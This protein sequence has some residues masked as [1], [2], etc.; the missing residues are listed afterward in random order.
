M[1][2]FLALLPALIMIV[3]VIT[4]RK[5]LISLGIGILIAAFIYAD[6]N[7]I[8][9]ITYIAES[10]WGIATSFDWY[11]PILGFVVIIG[12]I[13]AVI[14][15]SG[16][17]QAFAKWSV[18]KVKNPVAAQ[19]LTWIL[20]LIICIDDYFNALVIGEVSKPITDQYQI[21]RAKLAYIIDSTS[22]PVVIL[23]PISTWGAYIIGLMGALFVEAGYVT[24]TGFSGFVSAIPYQFYPIT[25]IVV[26]FLTIKYNIRL[27]DMKKYE[28][29]AEEGNDISKLEAIAEVAQAKIEG[30]KATQWTLI[31]P[32]VLL[33]FVT[34]FVMLLKANFQFSSIMDQEITVPLFLGGVVAFLTSLIFALS[35]RNIRPKSIFKVSAIGMGAMFK[36]AVAILVLAW[37]VSGAIQDLDTG[38][39][40]AELISGSQLSQSLIPLVLFLIASG[41]AFST[42]T[43]W[44]SF[45]ILLPIAVPIAMATNP[46]LM[47]VII[48]AVLGGAVFGDHSSP[49]SDTTVLSA[50][51]AQSTLQA[52]FI[53]QLP[54]ALITAGFAAIGYLVYGLTGV[55]IISYV[56]IA[57][58]L[59]VFVKLYQYLTAERPAVLATEEE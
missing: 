10:F 47:P 39:L 23:M 22:A 44:G 57:I 7:I 54:Y 26:V 56:V 28:N 49:V 1:Q 14:T 59:L 35:D 29:S 58:L 30:K 2:L 27:G 15:L 37:M 19:L 33:V 45:S 46:A 11:L 40:I 38:N 24:H 42:G 50:T 8:G 21:S 18:S 13:T 17:V 12:G 9:A 16:G 43:S 48:A 52:H 51:G 20:G 36:S 53:S 55:L 34:F 5:V 3:L 31:V 25:A 41:M 32:I 6:Y 4:T